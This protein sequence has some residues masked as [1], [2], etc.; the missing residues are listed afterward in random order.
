MGCI[1]T[2]TCWYKFLLLLNL[3]DLSILLLPKAALSTL[4]TPLSLSSEH[5]Q[6]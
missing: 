2:V 1:P 6:Q 3:S 5:K 4:K